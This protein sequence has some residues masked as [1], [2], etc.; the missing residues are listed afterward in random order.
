M[1]R[2]CLYAFALLSSMGH[3]RTPPHMHLHVSNYSID[4]FSYIMHTNTMVML[5][6]VYRRISKHAFVTRENARN[7]T[8]NDD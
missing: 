4:C 2:V 6:V 5:Q 1:R 3:T 7:S 8:G